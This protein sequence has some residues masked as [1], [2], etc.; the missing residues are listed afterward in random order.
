[1]RQPL[2]VKVSVAFDS[3]IRTGCQV[4]I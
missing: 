3:H 4:E 2:Y 1:M